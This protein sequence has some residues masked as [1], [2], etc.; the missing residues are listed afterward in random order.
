MLGRCAYPIAL[1]LTLAPPAAAQQLDVP[2]RIPVTDGQTA[3][4]A[5]ST[6]TG[7]DPNGDGFLALRSG[8]GTEFRKIGELHNGDVVFT[9]DASGPWV[10]IQLRY[11]N[12]GAP[13]GP[14]GW[15]HGRWLKPLAG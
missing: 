13:A 7:L 2:V 4:C 15:V 12:P 3:T 5:S 14:G 6:V 8:P 10:G 9:C 1:V 11:P